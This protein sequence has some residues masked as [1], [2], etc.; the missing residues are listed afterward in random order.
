MHHHYPPTLKKTIANRHPHLDVCVGIQRLHP[1]RHAQ[2]FGLG[3]ELGEE[4]F[5]IQIESVGVVEDGVDEANGAASV[6]Y[7]LLDVEDVFAGCLRAAHL[8]LL[9]VLHACFVF[10]FQ[11][12]R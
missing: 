6:P 1:L 10:V 3:Q 9:V 7:L 12:G 8:L 5:R 2:A 4:F 11:T